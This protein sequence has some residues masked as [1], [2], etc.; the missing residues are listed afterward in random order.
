MTD[1]RAPDVASSRILL[2]A[3]LVALATGAAASLL[4]GAATAHGASVAS[5]GEITL[6][7]NLVAYLVVALL[8]LIVAMFVYQRV[9]GPTLPVPGRVV[10]TAL[11]VALLAV[12]FV[13]LFGL[14]VGGGPSSSGGVPSGG[15]PT[16]PT[17][18]VSGTNNTTVARGPAFVVPGL[19]SWL[20]FAILVGGVVLVAVLVVPSVS[21]WLADRRRVPPEAPAAVAE[22]LRTALTKAA[23]HLDGGEDPRVVI[24]RLYGELLVRL[25]PKVGSVDPATPE[26]IR[27]LH[28][29]R[30]GIRPGA[31]AALTRLF[32][33][34][35]YST[36]P[37]GTEAVDRARQALR[38][39][40]E[41]LAGPTTAS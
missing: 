9:T 19:P 6:P 29:L 2:A 14:I 27:L 28:L 11:V 12:L 25:G 7:S 32:E 31:A 13:V 4:I 17:G 38:D 34:A 33:E 15:Q 22:E 37:M 1:R 16:G 24:V 39:A 23:A 30:L 5:A 21:D 8:V 41:D 40:L 10:V 3:L 26:E 18:N 35:R 36:H 20:P